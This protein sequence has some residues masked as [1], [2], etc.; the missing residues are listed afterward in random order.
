[1]G[2]C[3]S[4]SW[5]P[6]YAKHHVRATQRVNVALFPIVP[7]PLCQSRATHTKANTMHVAQIAHIAGKHL[8]VR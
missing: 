7:G 5:H 8:I 1:M 6:M 2:A 3:M 4:L